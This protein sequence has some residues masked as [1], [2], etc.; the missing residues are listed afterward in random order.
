MQRSSVAAA[1]SSSDSAVVGALHESM[2]SDEERPK[3][4]ISNERRSSGST[5][6]EEVTVYILSSGQHNNDSASSCVAEVQLKRVPLLAG[7]DSKS[8]AD[9]HSTSPS[10]STH[11]MPAS[12]AVDK[13]F[14]LSSLRQNR[15]FAAL[16]SALAILPTLLPVQY[17]Q[18]PIYGPRYFLPLTLE[19]STPWATVSSSNKF[20]GSGTDW[21]PHWQQM[22]SWLQT[23][24]QKQTQEQHTTQHDSPMEEGEEGEDEE[25]E[26]EDKTMKQ[27][28]LPNVE[29]LVME[30]TAMKSTAFLP[31][32]QLRKSTQKVTLQLH[33][34]RHR[35]RHQVHQRDHLVEMSLELMRMMAS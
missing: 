24:W 28:T 23:H 26:E 35:H 15:N 31:H 20:A 1:V 5:A 25:E 34:P 6:E 19:A 4:H 17:Y 7:A 29:N 10:H 2:D 18:H 30:P 16:R 3:Q 32:K 22:K 27:V 8:H 11:L 9:S 12:Y 33:H 21:R 13:A 14:L